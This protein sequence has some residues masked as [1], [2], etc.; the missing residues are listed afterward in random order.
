MKISSQAFLHQ[1]FIPSKYTCQ[2][3]GTSP[4]LSWQDVPKETKSLALIMEDPD[5][6]MGLWTHWILYNIP[7]EVTNLAE[8]VKVLPKGTEQGLNTLDETGYVPPCPP[9]GTHRYYFKLYALDIVLQPNAKFT[10]A[11]LKKA[12]E[13]HILAQAEL[14]GNYAKKPN[15]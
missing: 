2:G 14:M 3:V 8:N 5:A 9:S 6:P 11:T 7:P 13:K 1:E 12:M 15:P 4:E 10:N